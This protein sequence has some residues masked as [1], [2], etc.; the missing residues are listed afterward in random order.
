MSSD[1]RLNSFDQELQIFGYPFRGVVLTAVAS[2][3]RQ[4][5]SSDQRNNPREAMAHIGHHARGNANDIPMSVVETKCRTAR[6]SGTS[7]V[8]GLSEFELAFF[9]GPFVPEHNFIDF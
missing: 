5:F 7:A 3:I 8:C 4:L 1:K 9:A 6:I 2:V